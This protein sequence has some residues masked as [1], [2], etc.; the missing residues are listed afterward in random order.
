MSPGCLST[1]N[2]P[3]CIGSITSRSTRPPNSS[4]KA[5]VHGTPVRILPPSLA[6]PKHCWPPLPPVAAQLTTAATGGGCLGEHTNWFSAHEALLQTSGVV[7]LAVAH[8]VFGERWEVLLAVLVMYAVVGVVGTWLHR[9]FHIKGHWLEAFAWFHELR[10]LHFLHHLG[11]CKHNYAVLNFGLLS[12]D[13]WFGSFL[14]DD[15]RQGSPAAPDSNAAAAEVDLQEA[16]RSA[17]AEGRIDAAALKRALAC[18]RLASTALMQEVDS[19]VLAHHEHATLSQRRASM[20]MTRGAAA[21]VS[22]GLLIVLGVL[23]WHQSQAYLSRQPVAATQ[24][25]LDRAHMMRD[26]GFDALASV[27]PGDL[28]VQ[29]KATSL[30]VLLEATEVLA[31]FLLMKAWLGASVRPLLA[32]LLALALRLLLN[33]TTALPEPSGSVW[34]DPDVRAQLAQSRLFQP[35]LTTL[36]ARSDTLACVPVLVAVVAAREALLS[37]PDV[38]GW[39]LLTLGVVTVLVLCSAGLTLMLHLNWSFSVVLGMTLG[40]AAMSWAKRYADLWEVMLP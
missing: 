7:I 22:R 16:L 38:L 12:P 24:S 11:S 5:T 28:S 36:E 26:R 34:W 21:L 20:A 37:V 4:G 9:T 8:V 33:L 35:L 14:L 39:R 23:L 40:F 25:P 3:G 10:A 19:A 2:A 17:V 29:A 6:P 1:A 15:P 30:L 13:R 18:G 31:L 27:W 32:L